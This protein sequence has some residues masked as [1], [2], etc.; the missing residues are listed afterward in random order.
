MCMVSYNTI[1]V[2]GYKEHALK[3]EVSEAACVF[4]LLIL[5]LW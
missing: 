5:S 3:T 4:N 1:Y 2:F